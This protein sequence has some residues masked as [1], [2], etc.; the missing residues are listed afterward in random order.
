ME[1]PWESLEAPVAVV[2]GMLESLQNDALILDLAQC[3]FG[4]RPSLKAVSGQLDP[5]PGFSPAT[6]PHRRL[7]CQH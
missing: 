2:L 5:S 7:C 6:Q 3:W 4:F 1:I